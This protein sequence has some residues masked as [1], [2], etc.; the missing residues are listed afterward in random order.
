MTPTRK[1]PTSGI[2][3]L[4]DARKWHGTRPQW[5]EAEEAA[6]QPG[7]PDEWVSAAT[8]RSMAAV[9]QRRCAL[10]IPKTAFTGQFFGTYG[11]REIVV[12]IDGIVTKL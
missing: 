1:A 6:I 12:V 5:S 10:G 2:G 3:A 4:A 7:V 8:G 9:K 11:G